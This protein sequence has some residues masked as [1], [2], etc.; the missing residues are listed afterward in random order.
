MPTLLRLSRCFGEAEARD[1]EGS[2]RSIAEV[3]VAVA[4]VVEVVAWPAGDGEEGER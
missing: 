2:R 3:V 4:I 1:D